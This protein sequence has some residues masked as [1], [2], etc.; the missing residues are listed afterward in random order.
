MSENGE[1]YNAAKN[2]TLPPAL[3][4]WTNSTSGQ[5][6]YMTL[7]RLRCGRRRWGRLQNWRTVTWIAGGELAVKRLTLQGEISKRKKHFAH[8]HALCW[9]LVIFAT[10]WPDRRKCGSRRG[11]LRWGTRRCCSATGLGSWRRTMST[12]RESQLKL[13][14]SSEINILSWV[15]RWKHGPGEIES[16]N[17]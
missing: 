3:T 5:Q 12:R 7:T 8:V 11:R 10:L 2:F 13:K 6:Q 17:I 4:A 9:Q 14:A 1:I 16:Q 15:Q